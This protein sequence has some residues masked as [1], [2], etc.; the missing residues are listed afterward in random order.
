LRA[1]V[2]AHLEEASAPTRLTLIEEV[3]LNAAGKPDKKR[4]AAES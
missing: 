3:P 2:T 4:L 1:L